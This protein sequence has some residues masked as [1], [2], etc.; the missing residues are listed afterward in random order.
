VG[1]GKCAWAAPALVTVP[2]GSSS[3]RPRTRLRRFARE[4]NSPGG[5]RGFLRPNNPPS[6]VDRRLARR[7][8]RPRRWALLLGAGQG[9]HGRGRRF[10]CSKGSATFVGGLFERQRKAWGT[11][12]TWRTVPAGGKFRVYRNSGKRATCIKG[13]FVTGGPAGAASDRWIM[14]HVTRRRGDAETR[15]RGDAETRRRGDAE[16]RRRGDAET[17]RR[18]GAEIRRWKPRD[19]RS[20]SA[21]S[22]PPR[23]PLI[24][25]SSA[26]SPAC[27]RALSSKRLGNH[28]FSLI[29]TYLISQSMTISDHQWWL[30][31]NR[32]QRSDVR[33]P[34]DA[35]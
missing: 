13:D 32:R 9:G 12:Q 15:R 4:N 11:A 20:S 35:P 34:A 23:D 16:T 8:A 31:D 28:L 27:T 7:L 29:F 18:E 6:I 10:S 2:R 14:N 30:S 26:P 21:L 19:S 33:S 5:G 24:E 3:G 17:R 1:G 25:E 22:A